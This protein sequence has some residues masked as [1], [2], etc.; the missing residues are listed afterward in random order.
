MR[1]RARLASPVTP[2]GYWPSQAGCHC[3]EPL[4]SG[5]FLSMKFW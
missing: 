2:S 3:G 5:T 1:T 4:P